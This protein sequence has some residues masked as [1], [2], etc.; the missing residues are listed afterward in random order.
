MAQAP[1]SS[2]FNYFYCL[3]DFPEFLISKNVA[4]C[5]VTRITSQ[6]TI[7]RGIRFFRFNSIN[8]Q[9]NPSPSLPEM[10]SVVFHRILW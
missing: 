1:S 2:G 6:D 7:F 3:A 8:F 9:I 5:I 10:L 4:L